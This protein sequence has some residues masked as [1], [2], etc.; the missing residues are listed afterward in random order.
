M[1]MEPE[2]ACIYYAIFKGGFGQILDL[3]VN[4]GVEI[5]AVMRVEIPTGFGEDSFAGSVNVAQEKPDFP[6]SCFR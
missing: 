3:T 5:E 2:S 1:A 4:S 6:D